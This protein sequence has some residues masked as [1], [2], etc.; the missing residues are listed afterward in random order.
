MKA[1]PEGREPVFAGSPAGVA[2][3]RL[4]ALL[5]VLLQLE[6]AAPVLQMLR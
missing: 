5:C 3:H 4:G 2:E 6:Q 1:A